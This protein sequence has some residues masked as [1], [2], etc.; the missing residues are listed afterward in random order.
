MT[1]ESPRLTPN[2]PEAEMLKVEFA[3]CGKQVSEM[4]IKGERKPTTCIRDRYH[5]GLCYDAWHVMRD[6]TRDQ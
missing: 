2:W 5:D 1:G 4:V 6:N 3:A